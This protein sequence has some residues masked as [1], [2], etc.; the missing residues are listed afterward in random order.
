MDKYRFRQMTTG[1]DKG[2]TPGTAMRQL[3]D[4]PNVTA[5]VA[6]V[7]R[8]P[9]LR[10]VS[11]AANRAEMMGLLAAVHHSAGDALARMQAEDLASMA[12]AGVG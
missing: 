8:G 4:D 10:L 2:E 3:A 5:Y 11:M 12:P 6:L 7:K 9:D 1:L